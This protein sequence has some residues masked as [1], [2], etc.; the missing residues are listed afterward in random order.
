[1]S[2]SQWLA[3]TPSAIVKD[4][5]QISDETFAHFQKTKQYVV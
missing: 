4:H 1:M 2:L 3:L 5:L